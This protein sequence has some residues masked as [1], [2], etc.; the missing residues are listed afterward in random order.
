[1]TG[2][3]YLPNMAGSGGKWCLV[4]YLG[5]SAL[6]SGDSYLSIDDKG[7]LAVP[8]RFRDGLRELCASQLVVTV[9]PG[10]K[11]RCLLLYPQNEWRLVAQQ[12]KEMPNADPQVNTFRRLFVGRSVQ[13]EMDKQGRILLPG[14]HR[15][16]A[17]LDSQA[18]MVGLINKFEIWDENRWRERCD[19]WDDLDMNALEETSPLRGLNY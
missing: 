5:E 12:L 15:E 10:S 4:A 3:A 11:E 8:A 17:G 9:D 2:L 7:R 18:V 6:F 13:L 1:M 14:K 16:Y 19:A